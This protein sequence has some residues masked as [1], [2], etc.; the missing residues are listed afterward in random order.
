MD[1]IS[2][3][4]AAEKW[5]VSERHVRRYCNDRKIKGAIIE[6][7]VWIIPD[8]APKPKA[9]SRANVPI[10]R[11]ITLQPL[12][13]R[14][15]REYK[16]NNHFGIYE[17]LIANLTYSSNR[18]A[19][20]RLTFEQVLSIFRTNKVAKGFEATKVDDFIEAVNHIACVKMVLDYVTSP[21]S[22]DFLKK[23]HTLLFYGT[24]ADRKKEVRPGHYRNGRSKLGVFPGQIQGELAALIAEYE[25][26]ETIDLEIILDF[27]VRFEKIHPFE[28]GNGRIGRLV[29]L[30]ECLRFGIFP[31]IID[32]KH[33]SAYHKG[34][35]LWDTDRSAL[36][37][38]CTKAQ[39]TVEAKYELFQ[40]MDYCRPPTGRGAREE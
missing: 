29:L 14:V 10:Q 39:Q 24:F 40:L 33:R 19:S 6:N 37:Q 2:I 34:I 5:G 1:Y 31:F 7:G 38:L 11:E 26:T 17:Y 15:L 9:K 22:Q 32:D 28:D 30:K 8:N 36:L 18:M 35:Q 16:K 25:G 12:A 13:N 4:E 20:N 23:L 3:K 21:L 27:H